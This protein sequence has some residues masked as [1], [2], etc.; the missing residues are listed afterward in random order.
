MTRVVAGCVGP[1][2]PLTW[3]P[4]LPSPPGQQCTA[5]DLA[6]VTVTY[7]PP[8]GGTVGTAP[9]LAPS[10]TTVSGPPL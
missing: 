6:N 7:D 9:F 2:T 3:A 5:T 1:D 10:T 8:S 4:A